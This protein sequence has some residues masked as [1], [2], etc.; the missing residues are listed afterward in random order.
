MIWVSHEPSID[1]GASRPAWAE[2][3]LDR[4]ARNLERLRARVAPARI[5]AV[6]K[7]DAYGHGAGSVARFLEGHQ[8][9]HFAVAFVEEGIALRRAGV[10]GQVL[11]FAPSRAQEMPLIKRHGLSPTVSSLGQ[12]RAWAEWVAGHGASQAIHLKVDTG[13]TRLGVSMAEVPEALAILRACPGL[14][15]AGLL[16]HLAVSDEVDDRRTEDQ[17]QLLELVTEALSAAERER[18]EVHLANSGGALHHPRT[19][20]HRV[21]VGLALYGVDPARGRAG[22]V[23]LEPVLEVKAR[24][25]S[26]R[27]VPA[28][29]ALGY[30]GRRVAVRPARIGVV[31]VG[32]ADGFAWRLGDRGSIL[33]RGRRAAVAGPVSMDMTLIDITD[34]GG[35]VGDE[36]V[37]LGS[38]AGETITAWELA[39][40]GG[41]I[42]W[43]VLCRFGQRLERRAVSGPGDPG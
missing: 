23:G 14:E 35:E 32:Y 21:R 36:V 5:S 9:D 29:T 40:L 39:E 34:T 6:V 33:V 31:P 22:E 10:V 8:V 17:R 38:Q 16:S 1:P 20:A 37:L 19:R 15:L 18:A 3:R 28:G 25:V 12:L 24:L 4:L 41:T 13:M 2:V 30:G 42:P 11:V 26:T 27:Q 7:A 43:E